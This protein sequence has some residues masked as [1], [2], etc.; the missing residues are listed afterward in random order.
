MLKKSFLFLLVVIVFAA[1][2]NTSTQ[3]TENNNEAET[4][5][6]NV[7]IAD[8]ETKAAEFVDQEIKITGTV[9]HV[10]KHGGKKMVLINENGDAR[11]KIFSN[12]EIGPF[13]EALEG[14]MVEVIG[15]VNEFKADEVYIDEQVAHVKE[16][17][18]ADDPEGIEELESLEEWRKEIQESEKGYISYF[19][20]DIV[21]YEVL[22]AIDVEHD[23]EDEA[24]D[25]DEDDDDDDGNDDDDGDDGDDDASEDEG[26]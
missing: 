18:D 11:V 20:V 19:S 14:D 7:A 26:C 1:C 21:S 25:I 12:D 13:D 4:A 3:N 23:D 10:C 15:K 5:I 22:E 2:E 24:G 16:N 6:A 9:D 8:F 17:H